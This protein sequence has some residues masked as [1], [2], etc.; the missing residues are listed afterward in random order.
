MKY[1]VLIFIAQ[2]YRQNSKYK[3]AFEWLDKAIE[4]NEFRPE[5][6]TEKGYIYFEQGEY[7]KSRSIFLA[8]ITK[9]P[10]LFDGY[11]AL[12]WY[13]ES[14]GEWDEAINWYGKCIEKRYRWKAVC[15]GKI[16]AMNWQL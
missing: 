16:S 13:H 9:A 10:N 2:I 1:D 14:L 4:E 7:D 8:S 3:T 15:L 6:Y 12:G 5:A 11:W